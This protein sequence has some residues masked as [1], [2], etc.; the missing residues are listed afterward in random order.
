LFQ[1][2]GGLGEG[3]EAVQDETAAGEECLPG[4]TS[5]VVV[6]LVDIEEEFVHEGG[7]QDAR[8]IKDA[9]QL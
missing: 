5:G 1:V 9:M 8:G 7:V 3:G 6:G 4:D 2:D